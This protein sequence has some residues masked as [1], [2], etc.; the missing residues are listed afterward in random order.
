M[1]RHARRFRFTVAGSVCGLAAL[2]MPFQQSA[3]AGTAAPR[4][5]HGGV[6]LTMVAPDGRVV[7]EVSAG[8]SPAD[9]HCFVKP[10]NPH[11]SRGAGSVIYKTY[12]NCVGTLPQVVVRVQGRL[13]SISGPN[14]PRPPFGPPVPR[15]SSNEAQAIAIGGKATPFYT[16][17][18]GNIKVRG[19]AWYQGTSTAQITSPGLSNLGTIATARVFVAAG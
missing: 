14:G 7:N 5:G 18:Q 11:W 16:P 19:S 6:T 2:L 8:R 1:D 12:V 9:V 4:A 10:T 15:T 17:P 13:D 3:A